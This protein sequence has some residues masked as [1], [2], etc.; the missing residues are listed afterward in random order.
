MPQDLPPVAVPVA[1]PTYLHYASQPYHEPACDIGLPDL[2]MSIP[3]MSYANPH[4]SW[5]S[6]SYA[7][8]D[9]FGF[10]APVQQCP[11]PTPSPAAP[12]PQPQMQAAPVYVPATPA[13]LVPPPTQM[14]ETLVIRTLPQ[15]SVTS[16]QVLSPHSTGPFRPS[17]Y[18]LETDVLP[19]TPLQTAIFRK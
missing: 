18:Q 4:Q 3:G 14:P 7:D 1:I 16:H 12:V 17:V 9:F 11:Q 15:P 19:H 2:M 5:M 6:P 10:S 13:H 8:S